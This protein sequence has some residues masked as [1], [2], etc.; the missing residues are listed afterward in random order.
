MSQPIVGLEEEN[1]RVS[2]QV[3]SLSTQLIDLVG[4]QSQIEEQLQ[5]SKRENEQ[6]KAKL[7]ESESLQKRYKDLETT[8]KRVFQENEKLQKQIPV[9]TKERDEAKEEVSKLQKEV[10]E[11]TASLFD[12]ANNMVA[13]AN[14]KAD[15]FSRRNDNLIEQLRDK[16]L[17]MVDLQSQL[18]ELKEAILDRDDSPSPSANV[19]LEQ[20]NSF[21]GLPNTHINEAQ[22]VLFSP[23]ITALRYDLKLFGEFHKFIVNLPNTDILR[24]KDS[25]FFK[26]LF[27]DDIEPCLK[28]DSAAGIGW[29]HRRPLTSAMIEG[30]V[31]IEPVSGINET[32]RLNFQK[33]QTNTSGS[34]GEEL[35]QSNLYSYPSSSP[36]VAIASPCSL[37]GESRDDILEHSRLYTMKFHPK[38]TLSTT[39]AQTTNTTYPLCSYCLFRVRSTCDIFAFLR[40]LK[41]DIWKLNGGSSHGDLDEVMVKKAWIELARL[42]CRLFWAKVGI[43]DVESNI[44]NTKINPSMDDSLYSYLKGQMDPSATLTHQFGSTDSLNSNNIGA[45]SGTDGEVS[46]LN[47]PTVEYKSSPLAQ[48]MSQKGLVHEEEPE[49]EEEEE[50]TKEGEPKKEQTP[51][52]EEQFQ[53]KPLRLV[54]KSP[55]EQSPTTPTTT[56][57]TTSTETTASEPI[58]PSPTPTKEPTEEPEPITAKSPTPLHQ[59]EFDIL[60]TYGNDDD[61]EEE[62]EEEED[63]AQNSKNV[64]KVEVDENDTGFTF[65]KEE[66][67]PKSTTS[68]TNNDEEGRVESG[69][70]NTNVTTSTDD[71]EYV[72]A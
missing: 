43:W 35:V 44:I 15:G 63:Q 26:K 66:S 14:R 56:T 19:E 34:A 49:E 38:D 62:E 72:D 10:E 64:S 53:Q 16:D 65:D 46:A 1:K 7:S 47:S 48:E 61:E 60:D 3:S 20:T 6:L 2:M 5:Y 8:Y 40:S 68:T 39:L 22:P 28:L 59:A 42:R 32:Y 24:F 30:R 71:E 21:P 18:R 41:T 58:E 23:V 45:G 69:K 70:N 13:D 67:Q 12:E 11:L 37:C 51:Q 25:R 54:R 52:E 50:V 31:V 29:L 36:P 55:I 33:R 27:I 57:T 4:R 17:L 9:M